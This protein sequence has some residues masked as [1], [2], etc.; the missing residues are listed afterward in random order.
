[1]VARSAQRAFA[2]APRS[3]STARGS[4]TTEVARST[5]MPCQPGT[6][7][8]TSRC[9][10]HVDVA[11]IQDESILGQFDR[12]LDQSG[13]R[14]RAV[15]VPRILQTRYSAGDANCQPADRTQ[16]LDDVSV[17]VQVH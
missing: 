13:Q 1:R 3:S 4:R 17:L 11:L 9:S 15:L 8:A 14:H 10:E 7:V 6:G 5:S 12:R 16:A 2:V